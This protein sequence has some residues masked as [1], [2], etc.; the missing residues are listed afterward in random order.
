MKLYRARLEH[1]RNIREVTLD[2]S[3]PLTIIGGPNGIGKT[4]VQEAIL[5]ALFERDKKSRDSLISDFDPETPP[6]ATLEMSRSAGGAAT[7]VLSRTLTD[8][9]GT[10]KE[11]DTTLRAKGK[12]LEKVQESLPLPAEAAAL[13]LWGR[14]NELASILEQF[15][16]EGHALLTAATTKGAGPDPND[17][18]A[19]LDA[20]FR[21]AKRGG[22]NPGSLT[23]SEQ[24]A[25]KLEAD[26]AAARQAQE[27]LSRLEHKY[28]AAKTERDRLRGLRQEA[29]KEVQRLE[30]LVRLLASALQT[31]AEL[32][33]AE[34]TRRQWDAIDS[35]IAEAR[36]AGDEMHA[37]LLRLQSQHR[38]AQDADRV[39]QLKRLQRRLSLA[40]DADARRR[41]L[42]DQLQSRPRPAKEDMTRL[43]DLLGHRR[44]SENRLDATGLRYELTVLSGEQTV[45]VGEDNAL[46]ASITLVAGSTHE[47][48][49]GNVVV[50][51][52]QLRLV[53]RG[54]EDVTLLKR[55]SERTLQEIAAIIERF[56]VKLEADF[57]ALAE[58]RARLESE[59]HD[60]S[61][62]RDKHLQDD[63]L[64]SLEAD[65]ERLRQAREEHRPTPED[66]EA[67][68]TAVLPPLAELEK[69][70]VAKGRD[71]ENAESAASRLKRQRPSAAQQEQLAATVSGLRPK[72]GA[73]QEAFLDH[74]A[75]R[76]PPSRELLDQL[77]GDVRRVRAALDDAK[78]QLAEADRESARLGAEL[79]HAAPE[80]PI[81]TL[82]AELRDARAVLHREQ[83][84]QKARTLLRER[85]EQKKAELSESVP[86]ELGA[87]IGKHL[88]HL[89]GDAYPGVHLDEHLQVDRVSQAG[90]GRDWQPK[91]LSIGERALLAL[92]V[93]MAVARALAEAGNPVFIIL[94]DS[95]VDLDPGRRGAT[96]ELLLD[97]VADGNLQVILITC[98]TD[99]ALDWQ[100]R[101]P[102]K[103]R[104]IDFA[105]TAVY[106][107]PPAAGIGSAEG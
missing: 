40:Q 51:A 85:L 92:T 64:D 106:Y 104:Y 15:P 5:A 66:R 52:G 107:R 59:L 34:E 25:E 13:L 46:P 87:Q 32:A 30:S 10:W 91:K 48:V 96:E 102:G 71:L 12:A 2:L 19:T 60:A 53:A 67:W 9:S 81:P 72:A 41:R 89:T 39:E 35:Q 90:E 55:S 17:W 93:K 76:R 99:W 56:G 88:A 28:R 1:V 18:I 33:K 61:L 101:A 95:L 103:F 4:A 44:D 74:D 7:V 49:V 22:Q 78:D 70:V 65:C 79:Q 62:Q 37:E 57:R 82:E 98:H 77:Q 20:Q 26:L 6:T 100:R 63:T 84:L 29:E 38:L 24:A 75:E 16:T 69:R 23:R 31:G 73:A 105:R 80:R 43:S 21:E 50:R 8:R 11:G 47:G 14:Q 83:V 68:R 97:L 36:R 54:K 45:E 86:Q 27:S 58:Q 42:Q 94:D 3:S